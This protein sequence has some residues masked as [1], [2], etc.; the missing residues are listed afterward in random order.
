[1]KLCAWY[2]W[3]GSTLEEKSV[4]ISVYPNNRLMPEEQKES[5]FDPSIEDW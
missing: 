2:A 5:L 1:M 4:D 3:R